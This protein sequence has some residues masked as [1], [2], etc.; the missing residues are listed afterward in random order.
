MIIRLYI[1]FELL[2]IIYL[3]TKILVALGGTTNPFPV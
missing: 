1:A 2:L 3:L